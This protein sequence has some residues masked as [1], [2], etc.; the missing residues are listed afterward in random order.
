MIPPKDLQ[1]KTFTRTVR[2]YNSIEVDD[3]IKFVIAKYTQL[4][5]ENAE[6]DRRLHII[7]AKYEEIAND[8]DSIR[9][10]CEQAR[11][12]SESMIASAQKAADDILSKVQIRCDEMIE[13]AAAKV[14]SEKEA[15]I[16][17]RSGA[18]E[19]RQALVEQYTKQIEL[20]R[21]TQL[22]APEEAPSEFI[23]REKIQ[24]DAMAGLIPDE[25]IERAVLQ[26]TKDPKF[27]ELKRFVRPKRSK[28]SKKNAADKEQLT[29]QEALTEEIFR[30]A[31][32]EDDLSDDH[33][34]EIIAPEPDDAQITIEDI[35]VAEAL[36]P[37]RAPE[38]A[39]ADED[40]T[41]PS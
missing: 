12:L 16:K 29:R 5:K 28:S 20:M 15:L 18:A 39:A 19:F 11:K 21:E 31:V 13:D 14:E 1:N 33:A 40:T 38:E 2:G 30:I 27:D 23:E 4:Y 26:P 6:L 10:A 41:E 9:A 7:S 17:L 25:I 37:S 35:L 3:Y 34:A 36:K 22:P 32:D 8:E 24:S